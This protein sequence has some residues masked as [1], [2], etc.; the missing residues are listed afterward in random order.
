ML[1]IAL[2]S[3]LTFAM[4]CALVVIAEVCPLM[5]AVMPFICVAVA[6]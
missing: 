2:R 6:C 4:A 1:Y 3:P 5:V